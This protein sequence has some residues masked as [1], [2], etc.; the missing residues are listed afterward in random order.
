MKKFVNF[1]FIS[2]P[3]IPLFNLLID[4]VVYN[5]LIHG[6]PNIPYFFNFSFFPNYLCNYTSG[7]VLMN[8]FHYFES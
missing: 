3:L 4:L 1:S 5:S 8:N 6:L 7:S 2:P